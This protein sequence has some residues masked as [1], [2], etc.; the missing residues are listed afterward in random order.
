MQPSSEGGARVADPASPLAPH[1]GIGYLPRQQLPASVVPL[2]VKN[3]FLDL[4]EA[5][6]SPE[7]AGLSRARTLPTPGGAGDAEGD[8]SGPDDNGAANTSSDLYTTTTCDMFEQP[9]EWAW[10]NPNAVPSAVREEDLPNIASLPV[11]AAVYEAQ[12]A[13]TAAAAAAAA[14]GATGGIPFWT[15][16]ALMAMAPPQLAPGHQM[17]CM[18]P[19]AAAS[20]YQ[21][22]HPMYYPM[23]RYSRLPPDVAADEPLRP[24]PLQRAFSTTNAALLRVRWTVDGKILKSTDREKVSPEFELASGQGL[25]FRMVMKALSVSSEKGGGSFQRAKGKGTIELR[26]LNGVNGQVPDVTFRLAIGSGGDPSRQQPPRGPIT[27][28]FAEHSICGLAVGNDEWDFKKVVDS[29]T[30]TFVVVLEV[31]TD[32][33][34]R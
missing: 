8:D 21:V 3:T 22:Q 11:Q 6:G 29:R 31:N 32:A 25:R 17:M 26:C 24:L 4:Q 16:P 2:C 23:D 10:I 9:N 14:A 33:G 7:A 19:A 5:P 30:N 27:H 28:N 12:A 34:N 20:G 13:A 15:D 18:V 1:R